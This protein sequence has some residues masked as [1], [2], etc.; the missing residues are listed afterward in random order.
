MTSTTG[1][2]ARIPDKTSCA[3]CGDTPMNRDVNLRHRTCNQKSQ[4][5]E[6]YR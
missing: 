5:H 1:M 3:S 2:D 4:I 6:A